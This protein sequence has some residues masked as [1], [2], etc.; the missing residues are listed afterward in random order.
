MEKTIDQDLLS[1]VKEQGGM[2]YRLWEPSFPLIVLGRS[3]RPEDDLFGEN[4]AA[5][6]IKVI[7]RLGGGKSVLLAPG[8]LVISL[9]AETARF[10][11]H[12]YY[13]RAINQVIKKTLT[14]LGVGNIYFKGVSDL[15]LD[16][17]KILGCCLYITHWQRRWVFLYQGSLLFN[18]DLN[19]M[20]RYLRH[21]PWE[22]DYRRGRT[23]QEFLTTLTDQ[24]YRL[25]IM[26]FASHLA[27]SLDKDWP[28]ILT[29]SPQA[30]SLKSQEENLQERLQGC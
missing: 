26:L 28:R 22:P 30:P 7:K 19:T 2:R 15:A 1:M 23:H 9:A 16:D 11:G 25:N 27:S 3:S 14:A 21:P 6:S 24:G 4:C 18:L 12:L 20:A 29:S 17:R 5:D 10:L 8:M 13:A